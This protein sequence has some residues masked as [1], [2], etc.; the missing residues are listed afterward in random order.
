MVD[1]RVVACLGQIVSGRAWFREGEGCL[2]SAS[3][4]A[5]VG[6]SGPCQMRAWSAIQW[7]KKAPRRTLVETRMTLFRTNCA[8]GRVPPAIPAGVAC[9]WSRGYP[10]AVSGPSYP[11]PS[12]ALT[13]LATR[14]SF[15]SVNLESSERRNLVLA[16]LAP[17][18]PLYTHTALS[19]TV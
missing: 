6:S 5:W 2:R 16:L 9:D 18:A 17:P 11:I 7:T 13:S 15:E 4:T 14:L 8:D 1:P 10:S 19:V 3:D 12:Q